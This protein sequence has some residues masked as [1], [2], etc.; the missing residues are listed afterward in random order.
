MSLDPSGQGCCH[1]PRMAGPF[2][3]VESFGLS[4]YLNQFCEK[5]LQGWQE[6]RGARTSGSAEWLRSGVSM[7]RGR[8]SQEG[9]SRAGSEKEWVARD[10]KESID[11][12]MWPNEPRIGIQTVSQGKNTNSDTL[13]H[14]ARGCGRHCCLLPSPTGFSGHCINPAQGAHP[15]ARPRH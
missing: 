12:G 11:G 8:K 5:L 1:L 7:G 15:A 2:P 4:D 3:G 10:G 14:Q 6:D 9:E 13:L